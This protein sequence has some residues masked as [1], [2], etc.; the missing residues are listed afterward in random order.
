M[1]RSE[2]IW[3]K[4]FRKII[5]PKYLILLLIL[6]F[7]SACIKSD[8]PN[9]VRFSLNIKV[10]DINGDDITTLGD[11]GD[12]QLYIFDENLNYLDKINVSSEDIINKKQLDFL[13]RNN[14]SI[15][16]VVA[17]GNL[18]GN[19]NILPPIFSNSTQVNNALIQLKKG[20]NGH[21][22]NPDD[23]FAGTL[24]V[25]G[26][27]NS[28]NI[29]TIERKTAL[30]NLTAVG[31]P[32]NPVVQDYYF[33]IKGAEQ[34]AYNFL[35]DLTG[36]AI[37]YKQSA[38][39]L[40]AKNTLKAAQ[41]IITTNPFKVYPLSVGNRFVIEIYN[42]NNLIGVADKDDQGR[43]IVPVRGETV[44]I[45]LNFSGAAAPLEV[46]IEVTNWNDLYQWVVW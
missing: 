43:D 35:I 21:A 6:P 39:Y 29:I 3:M 46:K 34:D 17:W 42:G 15:L 45:L 30:M 31:I 26:Q 18:N 9:C 32:N 2:H 44:N 33:V 12:V 37:T 19:Q 28:N 23:L 27:C 14:S 7:L 38:S 13:Y 8:P 20:T 11:A 25:C 1:I 40:S 4:I 24:Q 16:W 36:S 22:I 10:L 41:S 5:L